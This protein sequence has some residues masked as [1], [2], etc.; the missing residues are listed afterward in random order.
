MT[1]WIT[2]TTQPMSR[3]TVESLRDLGYVVQI[4]SAD[5]FDIRAPLLR[6]DALEP[7]ADLSHDALPVTIHAV[8]EQG[9]A[10]PIAR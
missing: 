9:R 10:T 8:D 6:A 7:G 2:G 5:S 1:G 3:T 4:A